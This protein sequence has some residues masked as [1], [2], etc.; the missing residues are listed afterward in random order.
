MR[1][2][3]KYI[4]S[5]DLIFIFLLYVSGFFGTVVG[6]VI[7]Y[8]AFF[9]P[10]LLALVIVKRLG[11]A[12]SPPRLKINGEAVLM[13]LPVAAPTFALIFLISWVTSLVLSFLGDGSTPDVSG[14]IILVIFTHAALTAVCEEALFRY[15]PLALLAPYSKRAAVILS[16]LFF[17]LAHCNLFQIPYA[18]AAGIIFAAVD[19]AYNSIIPSLLLHFGNNLISVIW[20]RGATDGGFVKI[21]IAVLLSAA[22]LS[23]IPVFLMRKKYK[24][25]LTFA[26]ENTG[27]DYVHR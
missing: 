14:N 18:F 7:Y 26:F 5:L 24:T 19:V 23:L 22:V 21:Y 27:R 1:N 9:L 15:I 17:A 10:V 6:R 4:L 8:L 2:A 11:I 20:L 12:F 16:S 13:T 3:L 25:A